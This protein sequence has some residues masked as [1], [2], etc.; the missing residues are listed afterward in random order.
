MSGADV[1]CGS[2]VMAPD[3]T[4]MVTTNGDTTEQSYEEARSSQ[5][6]MSV[7]ALVA[8]VVLGVGGVYMLGARIVSASRRE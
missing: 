4:C 7:I 5:G 1:M 6:R 2:Q 8:G 3:D